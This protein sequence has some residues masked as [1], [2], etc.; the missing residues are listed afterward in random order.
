MSRAL[1]PRLCLAS[2]APLLGLR[3]VVAPTERSP[4]AISVYRG[5]TEHEA[6]Q[7]V[8]ASHTHDVSSQLLRLAGATVPGLPA[9]L[10]APPLTEW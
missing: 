2:A 3:V 5:N 9:L 6:T 8:L 7:V 4:Q 10:C 1:N